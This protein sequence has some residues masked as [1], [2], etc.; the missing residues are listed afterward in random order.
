MHSQDTVKLLNELIQ[1]SEDGKK[2]FTEASQ[3][4][5]K[6]DL[7]SLFKQRA[8]DCGTAVLELQTLVHSLGGTASD[9]G[10]VSGAMHRG[11]AK[12]KTAMGDAD[13]AV[14]E[15]VERAED[16]AKAA[17]Q[18]ALTGTLPQQ[19]RLVV[20]RQHDNAVRNHDIVRNLRDSYKSIKGIHAD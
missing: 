4:A 15:S 8:A 18:K 1:T 3:E 13:I 14:L 7:K 6:A 5:K 10:T 17:Y 11:W 19:I 16:K 20:Q 12:V 9:G 2:G